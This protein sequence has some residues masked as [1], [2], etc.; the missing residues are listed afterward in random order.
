MFIPVPSNNDPCLDLYRHMSLLKKNV[1]APADAPAF[2]YNKNKFINYKQ[3]TTSLKTTLKKAGLN[4]DL[5]SGHSFRRGGA[6]FLFICWCKSVDG[7]GLG[8]VVFAGLHQV[9]VYVRAGQA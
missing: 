2:T 7:A 6:I 8:R 3:F 5:F 4:P 1:P 9:L